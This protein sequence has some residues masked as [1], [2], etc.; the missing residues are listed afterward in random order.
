MHHRPWKK[1]KF[2]PTTL[3]AVVVLLPILFALVGYFFLLPDLERSQRAERLLA[4]LESNEDRWRQ[5]QP[6]GYRYVVERECY[7]PGEDVAPYTVSVA[8]GRLT[9]VTVANA[10]R[11]DD[12]FLIAASAAAGPK[13]VEVIFDPRFGYPSRITVDDLA[14]SRASVEVYRI[15]DFEVMD[16]GRPDGSD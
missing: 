13:D 4:E 3:I 14:G 11:I 8:S 15:R 12:L 10:I 5:T 9:G 1:T 6:A 7:C 16:Y 2:Q